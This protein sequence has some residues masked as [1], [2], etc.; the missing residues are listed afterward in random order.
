MAVKF[1]EKN[2]SYESLNPE[3]QINWMGVTT[4]VGLF[5]PK[6]DPVAQSL[7]SSK[8]KRSKWY[9]VDPLKIQEIWAREGERANTEGTRYHNQRES[10]ILSFDT[11]DRSG[12]KVPI[13]KPIFDGEIKI[14]P[15]QKLIEGIYPEHFVYLKSAGL[16]GQSDRVEVVKNII[17]VYDYKTNKEIKMEGFTNWEG[18]VEKM[19]YPI[20][21]L[22]NCNYNHYALQLSTYMYIMLKHNPHYKPGKLM[23]HHV[24][25]KKE[26]ED[27]YGYPILQRDEHGDAIVEDVIPYEVPYLRSEVIAMLN[28]YKDNAPKK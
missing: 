22:D 6:F 23:L 7:K 17:D 1:K 3:E 24:V 14:A 16:C 19:S 28:W 11:I 8:N 20:G 4:F 9:G 12:V 21:H 10:D 15:S 25:F 27:E 2:H 13:I 5:K 18:K 26:G